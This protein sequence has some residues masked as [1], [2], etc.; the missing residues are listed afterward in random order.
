M[1]RSE[2]RKRR[3][4]KLIQNYTRIKKLDRDVLSALVDMITIGEAKEVE[5]DKITDVTIYYRFVGA[6]S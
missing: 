4:I 6:V 1:R 2:F 5:E 3:R